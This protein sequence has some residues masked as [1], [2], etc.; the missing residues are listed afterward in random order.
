MMSHALEL[1]HVSRSFGDFA[2]EDV[3]LTLPAGCVLGLVGENG[4]GKSTTIRLIMNALRRDSGEITVLGCDNTRPEFQQVK[5]DIGFVLD[6]AY[7]PEVLNARQVGQVLAKTYTHWDPVAYEGYL[8]RFALPEEKL[9]KDYSRGMRMKL[10]IAAAL[11]HGVKLLILD[12]ATAGLDPIARDEILDLFLEFTRDEDHSILISSHILSDLEKVCDY[13]A[14]LHEGRLMLCEE[15]DALMDTY[16]VAV[17]T[18]EQLRSLPEDAVVA[19]EENRYNTRA[20]VRRHEVPASL[21]LERAGIE[22][23]ILLLVKGGKRA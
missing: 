1:K 21:P 16:G 13:V 8:R 10:A 7:F 5:E 3:N 18:A 2:L 11:S 23:I 14:F 6:E 17:C 4:A 15:K 19:V 20:L 12:E 9:F 22:D